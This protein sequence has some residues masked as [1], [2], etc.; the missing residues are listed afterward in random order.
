MKKAIIALATASTVLLS[1]LYCAPY[2][3]ALTSDN[4][5]VEQAAE[6]REFINLTTTVTSVS[7]IRIKVYYTLNS[8]YSVLSGVS[9]ISYLYVPANIQP[10]GWEQLSIDGG[11]QIRI[12]LKYYNTS[13]QSD[14]CDYVYIYA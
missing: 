1:P 9:R 6:P 3:L 4:P 14:G 11:K 5:S 2:A 13:T 12:K 10:T 7:G 8:A